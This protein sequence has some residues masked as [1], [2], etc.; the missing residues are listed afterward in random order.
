[1]KKILII[2][3]FLFVMPMAGQKN[4]AILYFKDGTEL[5]GLAK[6]TSKKKIKFRTKKGAK[7]QLYNYLELD[8]VK[9][10]FNNW[11]RL[12]ISTYYYKKTEQFKYSLLK[13]IIKGK[14]SIY[15]KS[16]IQSGEDWSDMSTSEN[17]YYVWKEGDEIAVLIENFEQ[18]DN[19]FS[20]KN[21]KAAIRYFNDCPELVKKIENNEFK[22]TVNPL[23][24]R[25]DL[26]RVVNFY[27][28][29]CE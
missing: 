9:I 11:D 23:S 16:G 6:V 18:T 19:I 8:G 14:L 4:E 7:K 22:G 29:N 5:K 10:T 12:V 2:I 17:G 13:E 20:K 15:H 3:A 25:I 21:K 26:K 27:N 28:E 1:M 24:Q